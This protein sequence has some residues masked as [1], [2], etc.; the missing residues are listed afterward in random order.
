MNLFPSSL[1]IFT[2]YLLCI[3]VVFAD[4]AVW[5]LSIHLEQFSAWMGIFCSLSL[6]FT[7]QFRVYKALNLRVHIVR[8]LATKGYF[9]V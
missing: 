9:R 1:L 8:G 4:V 5:F 7:V 2:I 6:Q 3:A